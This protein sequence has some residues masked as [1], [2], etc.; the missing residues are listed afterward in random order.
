MKDLIALHQQ[1]SLL[2]IGAILA[3]FKQYILQF[4]R[5]LI[6]LKVSVNF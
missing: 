1:S 2:K 6:D 4:I 5:F 3:L